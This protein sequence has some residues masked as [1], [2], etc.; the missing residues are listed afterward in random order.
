MKNHAAKWVFAGYVAHEDEALPLFVLEGAVR[1]ARQ[2]RERAQMHGHERRDN[3]EYL[4]DG[5][6]KDE[7][8]QHSTRSS[9][10]ARESKH[11]KLY[12]QITSLD[13]QLADLDARYDRMADVLMQC[14]KIIGETNGA[15]QYD[16]D[17]LQG[18]LGADARKQLEQHLAELVENAANKKRDG[19]WMQVELHNLKTHI[20]QLEDQ[21]ERIEARMRKTTDHWLDDPKLKVPDW[22]YYY[23]LIDA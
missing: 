23:A 8:E 12:A 2:D 10:A 20:L 16:Q 5:L 13:A 15:M 22:D 7:R 4:R 19:A 18:L 21:Q 6:R 14:G 11:I 9:K 17:M 1:E 3:I